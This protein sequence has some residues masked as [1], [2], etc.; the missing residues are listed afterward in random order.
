MARKAPPKSSAAEKLLAALDEGLDL[1]GEYSAPSALTMPVEP[2]GSLLEQC[3][4]LCAQ[5]DAVTAEPVRTLH[6]FACTGGTLIS[7]CVAA[8]PN[9]QL[10]S[11]VDPLSTL[12][13]DPRGEP[14]MTP[15]DL[16]LLMRQSTR[17][18]SDRLLVEMFLQNLELIHAETTR[19]GQRLVLRDHTHSLYCHGPRI[20][21]RPGLRAIVASRFPVVSAVTVR[22]PL[23]SYLALTALGWISYS[24]LGLDEYCRRYL[25]FLADHADLPVLRYE[26]FLA[27]PESWVGELCGHL[28]LP[29]SADFASLFDAFRLTGD[30]GRGGREIASRPRREV[31]EGVARE[32]GES[33]NYRRLLE[34]LRYDE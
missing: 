9:T 18:V 8:M 21:D 33:A 10:L 25:V 23:D 7:K 3:L 24:P 16:S 17:G 27:A 22:H 20:P 28:L 2:P 1:L 12:L 15:T 34:K 4:E 11:E 31:G 14:R 26:D 30:S 32:A 6:H 13:L 29:Y 5:R 19:V